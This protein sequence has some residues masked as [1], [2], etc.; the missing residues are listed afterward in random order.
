M[1]VRGETIRHTQDGVQKVIDHIFANLGSIQMKEHFGGIKSWTVTKMMALDVMAITHRDI[2]R[3]V[4]LKGKTRHGKN[5]I[6]QHGME[7]LIENVS[8]FQGQP[9]ML[10]R[11]KNK[12]EGPKDNKGF[13]TRWV[14]LRDDPNFIF[15][16]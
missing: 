9:A 2:G 7:W 16:W 5:R 1:V 4:L 13:D 3:W 12:T 11:S 15:F 14:I 10:L 6:Q 8:T